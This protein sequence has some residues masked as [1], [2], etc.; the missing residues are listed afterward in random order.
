MILYESNDDPFLSVLEMLI[1][2]GA[3]ALGPLGER[4]LYGHDVR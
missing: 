3:G 2:E 1:C 4:A